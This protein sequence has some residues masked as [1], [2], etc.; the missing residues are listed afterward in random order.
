MDFSEK[1]SPTT[2]P[3]PSV[4]AEGLKD[5]LSGGILDLPENF[6]NNDDLFDLGLDSMAIMQLLILIEDRF[7]LP[8]PA[9]LVTKTHFCSIDALSKL[10]AELSSSPGQ[11]G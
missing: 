1:N 2:L 5:I 11:P 3:N 8:I 6:Q 10:L 4:F 7:S 9:N